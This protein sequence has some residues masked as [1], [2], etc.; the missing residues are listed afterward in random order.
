MKQIKSKK[1]KNKIPGDRVNL[2]IKNLIWNSTLVNYTYIYIK[3][4]QEGIYIE[5]DICFI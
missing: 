3:E 2:A 1:R 5:F 4:N